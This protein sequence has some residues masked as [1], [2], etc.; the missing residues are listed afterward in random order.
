[1]KPD[2]HVAAFHYTVQKTG[3]NELFSVGQEETLTAAMDAVEAALL[4]LQRATC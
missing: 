4:S 3:R 2:I 1:M